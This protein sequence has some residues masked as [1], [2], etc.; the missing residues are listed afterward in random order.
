MEDGETLHH[1]DVAENAGDQLARHGGPGGTFDTPVELHYEKPIQ[2]H[3]AE[4]GNHDA[5]HRRLRMAHAADKVVHAGDYRLEDGTHQ[6][7]AHVAGGDWQKLVAGAEE[8]QERRH[9]RLPEREGANGH[10][11]EQHEGV[12]Q[13][14]GRLLVFFLAE[15]DGEKRIAAHAH[16]H[17][18]GHNEEGDGEAYRDAPDADASDALPHEIAVHNIVERFNQHANDGWN[19]KLQDDFR[20]ARG[21]HG[22]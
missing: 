9:E 6:D 13:D 14:D 8:L 22:A 2:E 4:A 3:I 15:A 12:V 17:G 20:N 18:H 10:D 5:R 7:N 16:D 19:R 11:D 1:V 21:A